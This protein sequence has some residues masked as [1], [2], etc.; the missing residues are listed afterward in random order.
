MIEFG[1]D[2]GGIRG[3]PRRR[4]TAGVLVL[5]IALIVIGGG[6][7]THRSLLPEQWLNLLERLGR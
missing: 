1:V 5:V 3:R 6:M 4:R 2:C 7:A